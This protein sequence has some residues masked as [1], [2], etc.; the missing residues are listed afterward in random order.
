MEEKTLI[1]LLQRLATCESSIKSAHHRLDNMDE[2]TKSVQVLVVELK[3]MKE[4][5]EKLTAQLEVL[6]SKPAKRWE[7]LITG[8]VGTIA[9]ALGA[10]LVSLIV[11]G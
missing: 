4:Q 1:D 9:G 3:H 6:E 2:F 5:I 10:T 8:I 7:S 11:G